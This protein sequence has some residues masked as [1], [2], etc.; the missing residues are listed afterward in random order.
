MFNKVIK[1]KFLKSFAMSTKSLPISLVSAASFLSPDNSK[2]WN[3]AKIGSPVS[4][5]RGFPWLSFANGGFW[6]FILYT[7][8]T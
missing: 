2:F 7:D 5:I 6:G 1:S 4:S 3:V 8:I